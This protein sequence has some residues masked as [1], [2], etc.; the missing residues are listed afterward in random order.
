MSPAKLPFSLFTIC[1]TLVVPRIS[2][3]IINQCKSLKSS[4][5]H[6]A[7]KN[8]SPFY[9]LDFFAA[10][11]AECDVAFFAAIAAH[12]KNSAT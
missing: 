5:A 4:I 9:L 3:I 10:F 1:Y 8:G 11:V 7:D 2:T 6:W 12:L